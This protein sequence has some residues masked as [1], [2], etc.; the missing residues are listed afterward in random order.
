[1]ARLGEFETVSKIAPGAVGAVYSAHPAGSKDEPTFAVRVFEPDVLVV[2]EEEAEFQVDA[3]LARAEAL[4]RVGSA[5]ASATGGFAGSAIWA[6]VYDVG[7]LPDSPG[8]YYVTDLALAVEPS[9]EALRRT[10]VPVDA[11]GLG[12]IVGKV[13]RALRLGKQHA[14]RWHGR[15]SPGKVLLLSEGD[16]AHARIGLIDPLADD[17]ERL[18]DGELAD[19]RAVGEIV[20]ALV[21][22]QRPKNV[23]RV[24]DPRAW[25]AALGKDAEKWIELVHALLDPSES[26][27]RPSIDQLD[28]Q[29]EALREGAARK[30]ETKSVAVTRTDLKPPTL[31]AVPKSVMWGGTR[32]RDLPVARSKKSEGGP[33][34][35]VGPVSAV[36][37][38]GAP[39]SAVGLSGAVPAMDATPRL[40]NLSPLQVTPVAAAAAEA[41]KGGASR[42]AMVQAPGPL[43]PAG[44]VHGAE[45]AGGGKG[46]STRAPMPGSSEALKHWGAKAPAPVKKKRTGLYVGAAVVA[47]AGLGAGA[48]LMT[49]KA[50]PPTNG[51]GESPN[52]GGS[53]VGTSG[54]GGGGDGGTASVVSTTSGEGSTGKPPTNAGRPETGAVISR[55][56]A[57]RRADEVLP[58]LTS[59]RAS[60]PAW[61]EA[62]IG[63][64]NQERQKATEDAI[65]RSSRG[66]GEE[67]NASALDN[68]LNESKARVSAKLGHA[69]E[70]L[71][72]LL[73]VGDA[74]ADAHAVD[75]DDAA[76]GT[77][78]W[79]AR[80]GEIESEATWKA[81]LAPL[82]AEIDGLKSARAESDA[83]KLAAGLASGAGRGSTPARAAL[84]F[85]RLGELNWP[86]T[87]DGLDALSK[88]RAGTLNAVE[89]V[90]SPDRKGE[91]RRLVD[92][93]TSRGWARAAQG[94]TD[95]AS[96]ASAMNARQGLGVGDDA[97]TPELKVNVR[98]AALHAS[99]ATM[100]TQDQLKGA[101]AAIDRDL[102]GMNL[103]A[104]TKQKAEAALASLR[105]AS[106]KPPIPKVGP[107]GPSST[108]ATVRATGGINGDRAS[109]QV[110]NATIDFEKVA[111]SGANGRDVFIGAR[112]ATIADVIA[113]VGAAGKWNDFRD[114]MGLSTEDESSIDWTGPRGWAWNGRELTRHSEWLMVAG[115]ADQSPYPTGMTKARAP[116]T[117]APMQAISAQAAAY[118]AQLVGCR[119]PTSAEWKAAA[120]ASPTASPVK[121]DASCDAL[122]TYHAAQNW[123]PQ[124][125]QTFKKVGASGAGSASG[126]FVWFRTAQDSAERIRDLS[127]NVAEFVL[128]KAGIVQ[129]SG[130]D[131]VRSFLGQAA[132]DRALGV[133]GGSRLWPP[134]D[135][136]DQPAWLADQADGLKSASDSYSDVGF[137]LAFNAPT[138]GPENIK[139]QIEAERAS[140]KLVRAE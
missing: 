11:V 23:F 88:A 105:T 116:T 125:G 22:H 136:G 70:V 83:A 78:Q 46:A 99:L 26:A 18:D 76:P 95:F 113:I 75:V 80:A 140:L 122:A 63:A 36:G 2:G 134:G 41:A 60:T 104:P 128:D 10:R 30:T 91:M 34:G 135:A 115:F 119:F 97:I 43:A 111:G 55:E 58:P 82:K 84:T 9:L 66:A 137:R 138:V 72:D 121:W 5:V 129:A 12:A 45:G 117:S 37:V 19:Q 126:T 118:V 21:Q 133:I 44:G 6:P 50:A 65:R 16:L 130:A 123:G 94:A 62:F 110:G 100:E 127:G 89:A 132:G 79:R 67:V 28:E 14:G 4:A 29:L 17:D 13:V 93:V 31:D 59:G 64:V 3:F 53:E 124:F 32:T 86:S 98:L 120:R 52:G 39:V 1:M 56:D 73:A 7:K 107:E 90:V 40:S 20:Y 68:R 92:Q 96:L 27:A 61:A 139:E 57:V 85:A 48:F 69:R 47:I 109:F 33:A 15:L 42:S 131:A 25:T 112:E 108:A 106:T 71:Q 81:A 74:L 24:N 49:H 87:P 54:T 101:I 103:P 51:N 38:G 77:K 114:L 35:N 8:A 102:A